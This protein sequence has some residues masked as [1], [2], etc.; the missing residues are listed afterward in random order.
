[1]CYNTMME[2]NQK[3]TKTSPDLEDA[4]CQVF[5]QRKNTY[6]QVVEKGGECLLQRACFQKFMVYVCVYSLANILFTC[7]V[8]ICI[9]VVLKNLKVLAYSTLTRSFQ[10]QAE[11]VLF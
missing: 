7:I 8:Y 4:H 10:S 5:T 9:V 6:M 11:V 2:L 1:M 3:C